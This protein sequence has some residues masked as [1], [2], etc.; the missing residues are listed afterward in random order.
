MDVTPDTYLHVLILES[1][2]MTA[3]CFVDVHFLLLVKHPFHVNRA[4]QATLT[5]FLLKILEKGY[6][7]KRPVPPLMQLPLKLCG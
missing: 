3:K 6:G 1:T 5:S 2:L 7:L 4:D